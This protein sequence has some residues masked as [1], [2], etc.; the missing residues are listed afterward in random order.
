MDCRKATF[1][2]KAIMLEEL[3]V[4]VVSSVTDKFWIFYPI[5]KELLI[6]YKQVSTDL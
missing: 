4:I 1:K 5:F 3:A 6:P 2:M